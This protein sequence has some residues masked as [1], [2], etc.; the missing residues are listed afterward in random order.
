MRFFRK[1]Q[2]ESAPFFQ[3]LQ[4]ALKSNAAGLQQGVLFFQFNV[5][6]RTLLI[7]DKYVC[8]KINFSET[9]DNVVVAF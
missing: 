1:R 4:P 8:N 5:E 6:H 7:G 9:E 3:G 2:N